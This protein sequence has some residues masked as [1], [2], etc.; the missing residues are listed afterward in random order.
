MLG[1]EEF[2]VLR[3]YLGEGISKAAVARK[4][5]VSR[6]TSMTTPPDGQ[7]QPGVSGISCGY[8][9][10]AG[11]RSPTVAVATHMTESAAP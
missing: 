10:S 11:I 3:H 6:M 2:I 5:G 1:K 8:R 9:Y 7:R 4:M